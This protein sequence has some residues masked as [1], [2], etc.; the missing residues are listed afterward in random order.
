MPIQ[1]CLASAGAP[2]GT[3][4][5]WEGKER[6]SDRVLY[7][8][9]SRTSSFAGTSSFAASARPALRSQHPLDPGVLHCLVLRTPVR[10][11]PSCS[12]ALPAAPS[13][14]RRVPRSRRCHA[15][16]PAWCRCVRPGPSSSRDIHHLCSL[17]LKGGRGASTHVRRGIASAPRGAGESSKT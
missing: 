4:R 11:A 14:P 9:S 7:S 2:A 3:C 17:E 5:S 15:D 12:R 6:L 8:T 13:S 16:G 10:C 1:P